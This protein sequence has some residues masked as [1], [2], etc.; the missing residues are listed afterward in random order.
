MC[1]VGTA[2]ALKKQRPIRAGDEGG[3]SSIFSRERTMSPIVLIIIVILILVVLGGGYG[4]RR[5]NNVLA[6]GGGLLGLILIILLILFL[7]GQIHL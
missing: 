1:L 3:Y 7:A 6:G 2:L 4:Y 5:G